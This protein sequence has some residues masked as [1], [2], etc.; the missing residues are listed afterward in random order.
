[1]NSQCMF[2]HFGRRLLQR[3]YSLSRKLQLPFKIGILIH[4]IKQVVVDNRKLTPDGRAHIPVIIHISVKN[5]T[6]IYCF[7]FVCLSPANSRQ[8]EKQQPITAPNVK[9]SNCNFCDL[10]TDNPQGDLRCNYLRL[11]KTGHDIDVKQAV[12]G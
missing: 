4:K 6:Q 1:M 12:T 7:R 3:F 11:R 8:A 10:H 5:I 9:K 2:N